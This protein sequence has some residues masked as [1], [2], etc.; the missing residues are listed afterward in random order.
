MAAANAD[1]PVTI[2]YAFKQS[3]AA[4]EGLTSPG[5]ATFLQAVFDAGF[6]VDGTCQYVLKER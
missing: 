5:W 2:Y 6:A 4:E 3:E 1:F